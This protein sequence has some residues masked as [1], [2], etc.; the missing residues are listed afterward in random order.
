MCKLRGV[1]SCLRSDTVRAW[2][3]NH[4]ETSSEGTIHPRRTVS[5]P[6][7]DFTALLLATL[8]PVLAGGLVPPPPWSHFLRA[9]RNLEG[10][11][12]KVLSFWALV[13][14]QNHR[15]A[16][17][18]GYMWLVK[19]GKWAARTPEKRVKVKVTQDVALQKE[20]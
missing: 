9:Y 13:V 6:F 4:W 1:F 15:F 10:H 2:G 19:A 14:S 5:D 12:K 7:G 18:I 16:P 11:W 3:Q 8:A 17:S 20:C